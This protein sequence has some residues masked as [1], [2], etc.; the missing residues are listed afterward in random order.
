M[1]SQSFHIKRMGKGIILIAGKHTETE[2][3]RILYRDRP[4]T[5]YSFVLP[6][7]NAGKK[8]RTAIRWIIDDAKGDFIILDLE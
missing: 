6:G 2:K 5:A 3:P 8:S 7:P 1:V 4:A